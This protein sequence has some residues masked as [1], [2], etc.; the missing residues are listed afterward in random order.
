VLNHYS[1]G[2]QNHP[3]LDSRLKGSNNRALVLN[4]PEKDKKAI[5]AFLNTLTDYQMITDPRFSNPF[6]LN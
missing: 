5:I 1:N 6:K 3:N 2:I 4:I